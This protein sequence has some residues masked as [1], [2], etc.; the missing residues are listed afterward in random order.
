MREG[1]LRF[2]KGKK[3]RGRRE[4]TERSGKEIEKLRGDDI[5]R[6]TH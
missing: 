2:E 4:D 6:G 5:E 1:I 3:S